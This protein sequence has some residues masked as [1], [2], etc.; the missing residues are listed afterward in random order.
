MR[1]D[2]KMLEEVAWACVVA[3]A[4]FAVQLL[5]EFD[6]AEVEDWRAYGVAAGSGAVRVV[7]AVLLAR[8]KR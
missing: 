5:V 4:V 8:L 6:A 7:G 1:Y 3:V 2:F